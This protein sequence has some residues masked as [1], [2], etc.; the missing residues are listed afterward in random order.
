[1]RSMN[2]ASVDLNL[3]VAF[4]AMMEERHV[5]RAAA[6]IGL[7]QPSMSNALKRLRAL[8]D[9]ELFVRSG[10]GMMP[11]R[12]ALTLEQPIAAALRQIKVALARDPIFDSASSRRR[13]AIAVTDYGD[14]GVVPRLIRLLRK[15]APGADLVVRPITDAATAI[16]ALARGELDALIGGHLPDSPQCV[17]RRLF[18]ERFVCIRD[19]A[20]AGLSSRWTLRDYANLPHAMFSS[21][22]GDGVPGVVDTI[23]ASHGLRRRVAATLA[24]VVAVPFAIAGTDLVATLAERI[25]TRFVTSAGLSVVSPHFEIP[26]FAIDLI[27]A[28]RAMGDPGSRWFTDTVGR[29]A[30]S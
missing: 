9:D 7:A 8:F 19:A 23:L 6:R 3:L 28:R 12:K 4:E 27:Q 10:M 26:A 18:D 14:L 29:A 21:V 17:R 24:H 15:E 1:M 25:A 30:C 2:L 13:F 20:H 16:E 11:T 5:T 22:G